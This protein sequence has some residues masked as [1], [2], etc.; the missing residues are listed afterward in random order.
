MPV[1]R[2]R[3]IADMPPPWTDPDDPRNLRRI[4]EMIALHRRLTPALQPGVRR[5]RS[6]EEANLDRNDPYRRDDPRLRL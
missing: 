1:E 5:F 6:I 2:Y 3:S 4:A